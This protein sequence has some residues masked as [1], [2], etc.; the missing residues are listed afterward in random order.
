MTSFCF[1]FSLIICLLSNFMT[2][3]PILLQVMLLGTDRQL[4]AAA[5]PECVMTLDMFLG[6]FC[7]LLSKRMNHVNESEPDAYKSGGQFLH[8][9]RL[10]S[11]IGVINVLPCRQS[12]YTNPYTATRR[13]SNGCTRHLLVAT[14]YNNCILIAGSNDYVFFNLSTT[15]LKLICKE[16]T[17]IFLRQVEKLRAIKD[18]KMPMA[19]FINGILIGQA[20]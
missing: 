4:E 19:R 9:L 18:L 13:H 15:M 11:L 5:T 14:I 16:E 2:L 3:F 7:Y 10:E 1:L 20:K 6:C 17:R 8:D 12:Q